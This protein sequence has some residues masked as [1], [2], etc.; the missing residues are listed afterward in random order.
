MIGRKNLEY[1]FFI[2]QIYDPWTISDKVK[3]FRE[4]AISCGSWEVTG[5][6]GCHR[7]DD[8]MSTK[9]K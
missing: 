3:K 5:G 1:F 6:L 9:I 7:E 8:K 4:A 2:D